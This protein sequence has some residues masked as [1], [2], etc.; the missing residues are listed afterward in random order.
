MKQSQELSL[1]P[2]IIA[3]FAITISFFILKPTAF[4][5]LYITRTAIWTVGFF[6]AG[7][8]FI[9]QFFIVYN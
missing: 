6:L 8:F 2:F 9:N 3:T 7:I 4:V 1:S 5:S